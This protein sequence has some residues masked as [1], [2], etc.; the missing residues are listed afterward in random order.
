MKRF[1]P[2][3]RTDWIKFQGEFQYHI[4]VNFDTC[5]LNLT[6]CGH[7]PKHIDQS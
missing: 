4:K 2:E 3:Y 7:T 5:G 6:R 1:P